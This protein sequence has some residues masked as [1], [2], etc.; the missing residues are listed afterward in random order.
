M[1][2]RRGDLPAADPL[3][4][5]LGVAPLRDS[6]RGDAPDADPDAA[7]GGRRASDPPVA[8]SSVTGPEDT[9]DQAAAD[10][11]AAETPPDQRGADASEPDADVSPRGG[12]APL[13][14]TSSADPGLPASRVPNPDAIKPTVRPE[15]DPFATAPLAALSPSAGS[16][17]TA[18]PLFGNPSLGEPTSGEALDGDAYAAE[19]AAPTLVDDAPTEAFPVAAPASGRH[20]ADPDE[21]ADLVAQWRAPRQTNRVTMGL[22]AALLVALGFFAGVLVGR[23]AGTSTSTGDTAR[24]AATGVARPGTLR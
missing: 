6:C 15:P 16:R 9:A 12:D 3:V 4:D 21:D 18:A 13:A 20:R 2:A 11:P 8:E 14:N 17:R 5:E 10:S 24:P 23:T 19:A 1:T 7:A 22:L